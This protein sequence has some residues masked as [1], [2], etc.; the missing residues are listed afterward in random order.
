MFKT[1]TVGTITLLLG[2]YAGI[3]IGHSATKGN[4]D[5]KVDELQKQVTEISKR[6]DEAGKTLGEKVRGKFEELDNKVNQLAMRIGGPGGNGPM[7]EFGGGPM[8]SNPVMER[9]LREMS[10]E[11]REHFMQGRG[12]RREGR[13]PQPPMQPDEED[14]L[15]WLFE[16][17]R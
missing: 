17:G 8:Q 5:K 6:I 1:I 10:P 3:A 9:R 14:D 7:P 12:D 15:D 16:E 13:R 11:E 2:L 4:T